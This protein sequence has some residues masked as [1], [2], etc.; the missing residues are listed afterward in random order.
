MGG[1]DKLGR[2]EAARPC[3]PEKKGEK[4]KNKK[5]YGADNE[6]ERQ[7]CSIFVSDDGLIN[8]SNESGEAG[9]AGKQKQMS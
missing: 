3:I 4:C 2:I 5:A 1:K 7:S 8:H 6:S 9:I